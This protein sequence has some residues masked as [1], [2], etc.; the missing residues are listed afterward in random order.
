MKNEYEKNLSEEIK[1]VEE[2]ISSSSSIEFQK[3]MNSRIIQVETQFWEFSSRVNEN[4]GRMRKLINDIEL[5][6]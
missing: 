3:T 4:M 1:K 5:R 6:V 2:K